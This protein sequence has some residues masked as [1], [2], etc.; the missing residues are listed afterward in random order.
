MASHFVKMVQNGIEYAMLQDIAEGFEMLSRSEFKIDPAQE[1]ELWGHGTVIRYWLLELLVRALVEGG[2]RLGTIA[3]S[4]MN[5][6]PAGGQRCM[7]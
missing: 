2:N 1:A 4:S 7:A 5:P 3:P 6:P